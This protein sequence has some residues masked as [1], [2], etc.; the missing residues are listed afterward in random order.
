MIS[1]PPINS[2][3]LQVRPIVDLVLREVF[4]ARFIGASGV[5]VITAPF[6]ALDYKE[7][8]YMFVAITLA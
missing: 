6:P 3:L 8:P 7:F 4:S 5:V 1:A 2:A